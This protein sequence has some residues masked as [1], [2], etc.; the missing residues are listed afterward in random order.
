MGRAFLMDK[1][2]RT[3][4]A[5]SYAGRMAKV[6]SKGPHAHTTRSVGAIT[7]AR[8]PQKVVTAKK[9]REQKART[10]QVK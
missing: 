5:R 2:H 8:K 6:Y 7:R 4:H 1:R 10:E 9:L 3:P